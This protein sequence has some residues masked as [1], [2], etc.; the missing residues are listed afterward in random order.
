[1]TSDLGHF[2]R[3]ALLRSRGRTALIETR[4]A[5][6]VRTL[7]YDDVLDAAATLVEE[8]RG[9][10]LEPG[11]R[12][13]LLASNGP[14]WLITA[15]AVFWMGGVLVPI[16][17]RLL[18]DEQGALL[19]HA[20]P[21]L[22]VTERGFAEAL[23]GC[24]VPVLRIDGDWPEARPVE[25]LPPVAHRDP[26]AP[27]TIVYTSGTGGTPR[28]CQLS[29]RAY[30]A[31]WDA[32][33]RV[34]PLGPDDRWFSFL[35][36]NHAIDFMC[37]FL[38]P[39]AA[40]ATVVHQRLLRPEHLAWTLRTQGITHCAAV[41]A[42]L[43]AFESAL[44]A[45]LDELPAWKRL[46]IEGRME[47]HDRLTWA[48]PDERLARWLLGPVRASFAP[49]LRRIY[50]GGA[51]TDPQLVRTFV[52]WGLPVAVGYGLTEAGTV[53]TLQDLRPVRPDTVGRPLP[54]VELRIA[55]PDA[56]GV[57]EVLVRSD[58]LM[59]G[60]V[61]DP[62][63][64]EESFSGGFL[65]TGDVGRIDAAG[66]LQLLGRA[67]NRIVTSAGKN[68]YPEDVEAGLTELPCEELAVFAAGYLW[69]GRG[70]GGAAEELVAVVR[71]DVGALGP[72]L[73]ER[74]RRQPE[75][76][77]VRQLVVVD[78]PFPRTSTRKLR[79][80]V[81]AQQVRTAGLS[82]VAVLP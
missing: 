14:E 80:A 5:R 67:R 50:C 48:G 73:V 9:R 3:D 76:M 55:D 11:H 49:R 72:A 30:L 16:D 15:T 23:V 41:P 77:R 62:E 8:L 58:T 34:A 17:A 78:E 66:H 13:A 27:A 37:G 63:A 82:G 65:R 28:G 43:S 38:G 25:P 56:A 45:G 64:T 79:R 61:D 59:S 26:E 22:L 42:L 32:L 71:G 1:M 51:F 39:F 75:R 4:K 24:E 53:L 57:G 2:L 19:A 81:L 6:V 40:G 7:R 69:P 60:Y 12:V 44:R 21:R 36:T 31:Q 47:L 20:R 29:H 52:R 54:G 74:Q 10:G 70:L 35:P 33:D 46:V 18:P 68:V